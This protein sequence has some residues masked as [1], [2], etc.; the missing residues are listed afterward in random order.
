MVSSF[1]KGSWIYRNGGDRT[2]TTQE[3]LGDQGIGWN[4][5]AFVTNDIGFVVHGPAFCCGGHGPGELWETQDGGLT[6]SPV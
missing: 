3:D 5:V 6:W 4:D 1:S 2:W